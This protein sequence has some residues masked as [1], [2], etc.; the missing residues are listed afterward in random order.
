V[1]GQVVLVLNPKVVV[2]DGSN[3]YSSV[4]AELWPNSDHQLCVFHVIKDINKLILGAVR[5]MRKAMSRRRK[6]GRK[7]KRGRKRGN[8]KGPMRHGE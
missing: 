7:K 1:P 8:S 5:Q 4:L 3:L 6:A 2:T